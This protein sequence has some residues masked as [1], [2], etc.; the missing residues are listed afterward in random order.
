M[1]LTGLFK[2]KGGT[3]P[4]NKSLKIVIPY[5]HTILEQV[6]FVISQTIVNTGNSLNVLSDLEQ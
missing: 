6:M 3:A 1:I 4:F 5:Y 2:G